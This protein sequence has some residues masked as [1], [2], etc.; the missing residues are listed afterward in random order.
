MKNARFAVVAAVSALVLALGGC[1]QSK[2]DSGSMGAM[3]AKSESCS[4]TCSEKSTCSTK[5]KAS[6]GAMSETKK[7]GCCASKSTCTDKKN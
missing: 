7:D 6:M 2:T 5:E 4:S 1:A 3:G